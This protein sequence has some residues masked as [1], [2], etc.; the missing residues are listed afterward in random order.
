MA[1]QLKKYDYEF[2]WRHANVASVLSVNVY[3][4]QSHDFVEMMSS[5]VTAYHMGYEVP[6][7]RMTV[8]PLQ[9]MRAILQE[10]ER[11]NSTRATPA[12]KEGERES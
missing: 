11:E 9:H 12:P 4:P 3:T 2:E 7:V 8:M 5:C 1:A 10:I 6:Q